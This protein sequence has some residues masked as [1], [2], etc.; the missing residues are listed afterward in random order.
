MADPDP[1][2]CLPACKHSFWRYL[3]PA[4]YPCRHRSP[5]SS[6]ARN[7]TSDFTNPPF[8]STRLSPGRLLTSPLGKVFRIE[9][10]TTSTPSGLPTSATPHLTFRHRCWACDAQCFSKAPAAGLAW[11]FHH[12]FK[13]PP[14]SRLA[15]VSKEGEAIVTV[16]GAN[17]FT[18]VLPWLT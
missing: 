6:E 1:I 3:I 4:H 12:H 15:R 5:V 16:S 2:S 13:P 10:A 11:M 14:T 9:L 17:P 18:M 8:P 7:A